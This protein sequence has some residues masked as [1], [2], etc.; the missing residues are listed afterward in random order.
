MNLV[1]TP[2]QIDPHSENKEMYLV[3]SDRNSKFTYVVALN[4]LNT[5]TCSCPAWIWAYPKKNCKHIRRLLLWKSAQ[6]NNP[7]L[8]EK[9]PASRFTTVEV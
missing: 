4:N 9:K 8:V 5:W 1:F 7:E 2:K 6:P 3:E